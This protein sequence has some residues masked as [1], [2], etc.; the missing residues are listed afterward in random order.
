MLGNIYLDL[1]DEP[2]AERAYRIGFRR[3]DAHS[4]YN[5][6]AHLADRGEF[7]AGRKWLRAAAKGG[8]QWAVDRLAGC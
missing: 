8:D 1:G 5:L 6:A 7:S 4:A 3:G 2:S